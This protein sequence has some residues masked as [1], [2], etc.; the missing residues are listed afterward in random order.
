MYLIESAAVFGRI[1]ESLFGRLC[2]NSVDRVYES[3]LG[4]VWRVYLI[5]FG[6]IDIKWFKNILPGF[7]YLQVFKI[8]NLLFFS[9]IYGSD[10]AN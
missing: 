8:Y 7:Y 5:S 2:V 9:L 1:Y 3:L 6:H 4:S 10:M